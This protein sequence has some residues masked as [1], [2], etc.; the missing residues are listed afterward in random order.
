MC[1]IKIKYDSTETSTPPETETFEG[2]LKF[3]AKQPRFNHKGWLLVDAIIAK[4]GVID[5]SDIQPGKM[6]YISED[7]LFKQDSLDTLTALEIE[8]F[9]KSNFDA[10]VVAGPPKKTINGSD[11]YLTIPIAVKNRQ[12]IRDVL[13]N[14]TSE[15]SPEYTNI[16]L[17]ENGKHGNQAYNYRQ[18]KREYHKLAIVRNGTARGGR[19][20][21]VKLDSTDQ[22]EQYLNYRA[23]PETQPK[24]DNIDKLKEKVRMK[25]GEFDI[26]VP[27]EHEQL[28]NVYIS[29]VNNEIQAHKKTTTD[30]QAKLDGLQAKYDSLEETV[31]KF[32]SVDYIATA[33]ARLKLEDSVRPILG[34]T[35]KFDSVSDSEIKKQAL[36]KMNPD[37]DLNG[38]SDDYITARFDVEIEN[39]KYDSVAADFDNSRQIA[40]GARQEQ[41]QPE[42]IKASKS[43]FNDLAGVKT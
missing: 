41:G 28:A 32:D 11:V 36:N 25:F 1:E 4:V 30:L 27:K 3:D 35:F 42:H 34:E 17:P 2:Q 43:L 33:K 37:I 23:G 29:N 5:R 13:N 10:G 7:E 39:K 22:G 24:K 38:K 14:V 15:I 16:D 9:H 26:D 20:I 19:D 8:Q 12:V 40:A 31:K 18:I 21:R 6:E